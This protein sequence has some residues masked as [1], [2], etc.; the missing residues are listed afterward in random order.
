MSN[1]SRAIVHNFAYISTQFDKHCTVI[2]ITRECLV[3]MFAVASVCVSVCPSVCL[4]V[5]LSVVLRL[6][7]ALTE[8]VYFW[9]AGTSSEC[10]L[11]VTISMS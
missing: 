1:H 9:F 6:L 3:V 4:S 5:C 8:K 11:Q 7:T 2:F 10:L